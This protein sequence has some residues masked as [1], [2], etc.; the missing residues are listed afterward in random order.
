MS[1]TFTTW[2]EATA[3]LTN[4]E[5]G[6]LYTLIDTRSSYR[7]WDVT[8]T[9]DAR[10]DL[11]GYRR[12]TRVDDRKQLHKALLGL[13]AK[14]FITMRPRT[15][16]KVGTRYEDGYGWSAAK[17]GVPMVFR[18]RA[19]EYAKWLTGPQYTRLAWHEVMHA[20]VPQAAA[21]RQAITTERDGEQRAAEVRAYESEK[22]SLDTEPQRLAAF[23]GLLAEYTEKYGDGSVPLEDADYGGLLR[24][25]Q[26]SAKGLADFI[27][28]ERNDRIASVAAY[29]AERVAA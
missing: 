18:Y 21:L 16:V 20:T 8:R 26:R 2:S 29:E 4:N 22:R 24:N 11:N 7:D 3:D 25:I 28:Y 6:V 27:R 14:G 5:R 10:N 12:G 13:E 23:L 15:G 17:R 1:K 9:T 19:E